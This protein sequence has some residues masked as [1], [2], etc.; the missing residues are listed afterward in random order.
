MDTGIAVG[1]DTLF[2]FMSGKVGNECVCLVREFVEI[3][4]GVLQVMKS[5]LEIRFCVGC[6]GY[7]RR[8]VV[9]A[10]VVLWGFSLFL[11]YLRER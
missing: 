10:R 3:M 1:E 6:S 8:K 5:F 11:W 2:K 7:S 9:V 4:G